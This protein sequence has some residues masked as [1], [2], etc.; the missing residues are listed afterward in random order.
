MSA[1]LL[2]VGAS[3]LALLALWNAYV[4]VMGLY[5]AHL[6]GRLVG[7][8]H[9]LSLPTVAIGYGLDIATNLSVATLIFADMPREALVTDRL[10]RYK[11]GPADWRRSLA[12]WA[13][14]H[15]LDPF[16]PTGDH[17]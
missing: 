7:V 9:L 10:K 15:L 14:D 4:L 2:A 1:I 12:E 13:C 3:A 11:A 5:R 8:P 16:D 17:C 6:A